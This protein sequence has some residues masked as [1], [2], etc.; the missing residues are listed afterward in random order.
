MIFS[1]LHMK[2]LITFISYIALSKYNRYDNE[3]KVNSQNQYK[4]KL[5]FILKKINQ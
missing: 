1:K 4:I 3:V 2:S 5:Y